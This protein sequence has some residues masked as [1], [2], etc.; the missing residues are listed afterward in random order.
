MNRFFFLVAALAAV[1]A[2]LASACGAH[3]NATCES[4]VST[5]ATIDGTIALSGLNVTLCLNGTCG[6]ATVGGTIT[7]PLFNA[8]VSGDQGT[9]FPCGVDGAAGCAAGADAAF[10]PSSIGVGAFSNYE[11]LHDGDVWSL[12]VTASD[13]SVL[14]QRS[15]AVTYMVSDVCGTMC[16]QSGF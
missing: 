7:T 8:T 3:C 14:A 16:R 6:S 1:A 5:G 9:V 13:G 10:A 4:E 15:Q 11:T 12:T 2:A